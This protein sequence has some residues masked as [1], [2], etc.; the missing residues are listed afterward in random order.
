MSG[1]LG[2]FYFL[3]SCTHIR[4]LFSE[5]GPFLI[6]NSHKMFNDGVEE[7][8]SVHVFL[9][10]PYVYIRKNRIR[11]MCRSATGIIETNQT[12]TVLLAS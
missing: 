2:R 8:G 12:P 3:E 11:N 1:N 6:L 9:T 10:S 7:G 5:L 4:I